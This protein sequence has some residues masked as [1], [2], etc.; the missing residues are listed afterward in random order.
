MISQIFRKAASRAFFQQMCPF[1][2]TPKVLLDIQARAR[3]LNKTIILPETFETR[4]IEAKALIEQNQ[5][6]NVM[7]VEN[8]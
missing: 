4:N 8:P 5:I 6:A 7:W 3:K 2:S 1:A